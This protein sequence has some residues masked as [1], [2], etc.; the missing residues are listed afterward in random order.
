MTEHLRSSAAAACLFCAGFATAVSADPVHYYVGNHYV[1]NI[2]PCND[3]V[4]ITSAA[5]PWC[6]LSKLA[7][8]TLKPGDVIHLANGSKWQDQFLTFDHTEVGTVTNGIINPIKLTSYQPPG[9]ESKARPHITS[10]KR[11]AAEQNPLRAIKFV[12]P[13]NWIIENLEI[14][15][16]GAGLLFQYKDIGS[17]SYENIRISNVVV[18][19]IYGVVW[20]AQ[21][22]STGKDLPAPPEVDVFFP[23]GIVFTGRGLVQ[24]NIVKNIIVED[25]H[26]YRN[27]ASISFYFPEMVQGSGKKIAAMD[28]WLNRLYLH[29]DN[30]AGEAT[31]CSDSLRLVNVSKVTL[32]NSIL[33]REASCYAPRGTAAVFAGYTQQVT[34]I[35][36]IIRDT[37]VTKDPTGVSASPDQSAID[38]EIDNYAAGIF[39]NVI[40]GNRMGLE[41]MMFHNPG[42]LCYFDARDNAFLVHRDAAF[43]A[44]GTKNYAGKGLEDRDNPGHYLKSKFKHNFFYA[45]PGS[46]FFEIKAESLSP[47]SPEAAT[48]SSDSIQSLTYVNTQPYPWLRYICTRD[49]GGNETNVALPSLDAFHAASRDFKSSGNATGAWHYYWYNGSWNLMTFDELRGRWQASSSQAEPYISRFELRPIQN[50]KVALAW[51]APR[52]GWIAIRGRVAK[53]EIASAASN[54]PVRVDGTNAAGDGAR[55]RIFKRTAM[56]GGTEVPLWPPASGTSDPTYQFVD[57][58]NLLGYPS[59]SAKA[60]WVNQGEFIVFEA[61]VG[62]FG[63]ATGDRLSWAPMISYVDDEQHAIQWNF[64]TP[65]WLENWR[66]FV[67]LS[68]PVIQSGILKMLVS[69]GDPS[70]ASSELKIPLAHNGTNMV[71]STDCGNET[72]A[73]PTLKLDGNRYKFFTVRMKHN[74]PGI[75]TR[76]M[77]RWMFEGDTQFIDRSNPSTLQAISVTDQW[78]SYTV[79]LSQPW[80][81]RIITRLRLDP[82]DYEEHAIKR[83]EVEID[84]MRLDQAAPSLP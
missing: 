78:K 7:A 68:N 4:T 27:Q 9:G 10:S 8:V 84:F 61:D 53:A 76:V 56:V 67:H 13:K 81:D 44:F 2:R 26:G 14:S 73:N 75:T 71:G 79:D 31:S 46:R 18:H 52:A 17:N 62:K 58:A 36:N 64:D 65:Q 77:L 66:D 34:V 6:N 74:L 15:Q 32:M 33:E 59:E 21:K 54:I 47:N 29:D 51:K 80:K 60:E 83:P 35:N 42:D 48:A 12:N 11:T 38:L 82:I 20:Q 49:A 23:A 37:P 3:T 45:L 30:G 41:C 43:F 40:S 22:D 39:G 1:G 24:R 70:M 69:G 16:V 25:V 63:N 72:A 19:D 55:A 57:A 28:I 50:G 5:T